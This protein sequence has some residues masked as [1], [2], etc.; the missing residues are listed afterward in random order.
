MKL[1]GIMLMRIKNGVI[2]LLCMICCIVSLSSCREKEKE[3]PTVKAKLDDKMQQILKDPSVMRI[4]DAAGS[5][6]IYY[7][8]GICVIYQPNHNNKVI[9]VTYLQDGSWS[10]YCFVKN[11]KVNKYKEYP[12]KTNLDGKIIYDTYIKPFLEAEEVSSDNKEQTMVLSIE[13]GNLKENWTTTLKWKSFIEFRRDT[14]PTDVHLYYIGYKDYKNII[15]AILSELKEAN[16]QIGAKYEE[17]IDKILNSDIEWK[18][19]A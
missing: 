11:I 12:P 1:R 8:E 4:D 9:T 15:E 7:D 14:S 17:A 10:T 19:T 2:L 16:A 6:Y 13:F 5:S 3:Y 18:M